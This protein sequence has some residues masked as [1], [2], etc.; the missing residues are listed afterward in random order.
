MKSKGVIKIQ[1]YLVD[2]I[3][4]D[5]VSSIVIEYLSN[6]NI[7]SKNK[8]KFIHYMNKE[9]SL[10]VSVYNT[11]MKHNY[12][13]KTLLPCTIYE[14]CKYNALAIVPDCF[15][16]S[17]TETYVNGTASTSFLRRIPKVMIRRE[18]IKTHL[19]KL[20][21]PFK[22]KKSKNVSDQE[23]KDFKNRLLTVKYAIEHE[24]MHLVQYYFYHPK[25]F[26]TTESYATDKGYILSECEYQPLMI[27]A[28]CNFIQNYVNDGYWNNFSE[29]EKKRII[30]M[31]MGSKEKPINIS[32][33]NINIPASKYF[34]T[35][36]EDKKKYRKM[37][38][39]FYCQ[40]L[41]FI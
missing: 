14:N 40:M 16:V 25:Q 15:T 27:T 28:K 29:D 2:K 21:K 37:T 8:V 26:S 22:N 36:K 5:V 23:I 24:L 10:Q 18:I 4:Y 32:G 33:Y 31:Y 17:I 41:E 6:T 20:I 38:K 12:D 11:D 3:Y 13:I 19:S 39:A 30:K 9:F 34:L 1:P 7:K 35:L